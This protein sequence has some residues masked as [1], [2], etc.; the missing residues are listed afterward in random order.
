MARN[1]PHISH[2]ARREQPPVN[3]K[4]RA[5]TLLVDT[6]N[7]FPFSLDCCRLRFE[8]DPAIHSLVLFKQSRTVPPVIRQSHPTKNIKYNRKYY[9]SD[10]W[11]RFLCGTSTANGGSEDVMLRLR[12]HSAAALRWPSTAPRTLGSVFQYKSGGTVSSCRVLF[13]LVAGTKNSQ[14]YSIDR[15]LGILDF[16]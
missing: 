3:H 14:S 10:I 7:R 12:T 8:C 16:W 15:I 6:I 4:K 5:N 1:M 13:R 11:R 9:F 2:K